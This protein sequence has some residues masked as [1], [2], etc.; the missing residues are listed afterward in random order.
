MKVMHKHADFSG[1]WKNLP[2]LTKIFETL[3][4]RIFLLVM[5]KKK[6][7]KEQT[8]ETSQILLDFYIHLVSYAKEPLSKHSCFIP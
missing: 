8:I 3:N 5:K 2:L 6:S 7:V 1:V 4:K